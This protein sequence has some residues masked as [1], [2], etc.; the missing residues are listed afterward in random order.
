MVTIVFL[1]LPIFSGIY[2]CNYIQL[3][4]LRQAGCTRVLQPQI[5]QKYTEYFSCVYH[6]RPQQMKCTHFYLIVGT[7]RFY[8]S[9]L[10]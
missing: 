5:V 7:L 8:E 4:E 1:L 10:A 6:N 9:Y 2:S 3:A